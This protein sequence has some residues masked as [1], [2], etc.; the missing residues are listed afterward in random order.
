MRFVHYYPRALVGNGGPTAAM[1]SWVKAL[2][3]DNQE[4]HVIYDEKWFG[5]Q[6][7]AVPDVPL[8]GIKHRLNGRWHYPVGLTELVDEQTVLILHSAFL[9][10]NLVAARMAARVG[11]KTVFTPHGAYDHDARQRNALLKRTW[12]GF[13]R[14]IVNRSLAVHAFVDTET[15]SIREVAPTVSIVTAPTPISI[16]QSHKWQGGGGY[17]AWLGRYD[18]E[19]KGLDLLIEAYRRIPKELRIPVHLHGRNSK[20]T[21]D[22]VEALVES[23]GL[24]DIISVGGPI[25]GDE[26]LRF[27]ASAEFFIMPSRWESFSIALLEVLAM[28]IPSIVSNTMPI[29]KQLIQEN[30]A[31]VASINVEELATCIE[32]AIINKVN[33]Y[34]K[35]FPLCFV[36]KNL[37]HEV[38]GHTF[39]QQIESLLF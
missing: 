1:W 16:P 11:A 13:E 20:N 34:K 9:A 36:Q 12:L 4:V 39:V 23:S 30:A 24:S 35:V 3:S 8:H 17:I 5:N 31:I 15:A 7:L 29:S 26:K 14:I 22:D 19:H 33:I 27:L 6:E 38:V 25:E 21:R 10:G 2:V 32:D 37:T 28:N 18:I